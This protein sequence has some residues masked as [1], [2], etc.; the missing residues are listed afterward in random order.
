MQKIAI[1]TDSSCDLS[2]EEREQKGIFMLP[3]QIM[4]KDAEYLDHITISPKE[5]YQNL[6]TEVPTTS[7]PSP[8]YMDQ[9]FDE[10]EAK[11]YTHVIGVLLSSGL[12]GTF[13]AIRLQ[14]QDRTAF[15]FELFDSGIVGYPLGT[16]VLKAYEL[17]QAGKSYEEIL[18]YLPVVRNNTF[19]YYTLETLEYLIKGGRIGKVAGT[20]GDFLNLKPIITVDEDG[21]YTTVSKARGRKQSI[22]KLKTIA[23][24]IVELGKCKLYILHGNSDLEA[25]ALKECFVG[26]PNITDLDIRDIGP[27]MGIHAGPGMIAFAIQKEC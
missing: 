16:I 14:I 9:V 5:I 7:L 25:V 19:G 26:H 12:S 11:G 2:K 10:I 4:Y 15:K 13:N 17:V 27:A 20:V 1:L 3:L 8:D 24:D 21:A 23:Q 18:A 6:E 22:K